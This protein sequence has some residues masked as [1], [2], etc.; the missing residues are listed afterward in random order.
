LDC[1]LVFGLAAALQFEWRYG[2]KSQTVAGSHGTGTETIERHGRSSTES[3]K[4]QPLRSALRKGASRLLHLPIVL[5][6]TSSNG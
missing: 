5:L 2:G 1:C 3:E 4:P 6:D